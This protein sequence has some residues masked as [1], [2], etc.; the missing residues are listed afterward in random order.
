ME[1]STLGG[2]IATRASG[3]KRSRYGNIED[4]VIEV[5]VATPSGI[6]WQHH[7]DKPLEGETAFGRVSANVMLPSLVLGSEGCLGVVTSAIVRVHPLPEKVAYESIIFADW[8]RGTVFMR[9]VARLPA[10]LR[11]ASCRLMDN[12]QLRLAQAL[13][14]DSSKSKWSLASAALKSLAL[15]ANGVSLD[16]ASAC[17]L[18]FEGS[19]TEVSAQRRALKPLFSQVGGI[20]GGASAGESG[21]A[22]TF[23][24]AYI[25]DF[26]ID[27]RILGE[28][29]ETMVPWSKLGKVWP[30]VQRAVEAEHLALHLAGRPF[31]S[32]RLTQLYSQGGVLYM[33]LAIHTGGLK[34]DRA[35][36]RFARLEHVAREAV[37]AAGGCLSHHHG[38]GK[39]RAQLLQRSQ[40]PELC[41]ALRGLKASL[42]PENVLAARN[43]AWATPA[44]WHRNDA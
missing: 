44:E 20:W 28:S 23:A 24:V 19:R 29:L 6:L 3:M 38:V 36:E 32:C 10:A 15:Y 18:V 2:W 17:T 1:L 35:L 21:Y 13:K 5:R 34:A 41:A 40:G 14:E 9:N 11:P 22:L 25:R 30:A 37:L 26:G 4:M 33:Y 42:D 16:T 43:G 12:K 39:H 27:Y 8:E 7:S 31:L